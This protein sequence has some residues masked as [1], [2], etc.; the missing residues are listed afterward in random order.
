VENRGESPVQ[1]VPTHP[2][3]AARAEKKKVPSVA[4]SS[5]SRKHV[6]NGHGGALLCPRPEPYCLGEDSVR[7]KV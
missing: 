2:R 5:P 7:S 3:A 6:D 4:R 1:V